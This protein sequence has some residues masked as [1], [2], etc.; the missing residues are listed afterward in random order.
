VI[1]VDGAWDMF[2]C[3]HVSLLRKAKSLGDLLI[4]GVHADAAV[5]RHRGSNYPIM[6]MQ[7]RVLSVLGCRYVDD[8]LLDAPWQVTREMIATLRISA[9]VRG[10]VCDTAREADDPHAVPKAMGIHQ[11]LQSEEPLSLEVITERLSTRRAEVQ[12]RQRSKASQEEQWYRNKHGLTV[13]LASELL[14]LTQTTAQVGGLDIAV[15]AL[16]LAGIYLPRLSYDEVVFLLLAAITT[17]V[18]VGRPGIFHA[19]SSMADD[20]FVNPEDLVSFTLCAVLLRCTTVSVTGFGCVGY[21]WLGYLLWTCSVIILELPLLLF[22]PQLSR[23]SFQAACGRRG[24]K[25]QYLVTHNVAY[26]HLDINEEAAV[27]QFMQLGATC[28]AVKAQAATV[29]ASEPMPVKLT[30]PAELQ[31]DIRLRKRRRNRCLSLQTSQRQMPG[32]S[33]LGRG[34]LHCRCDVERCCK[35]LAEDNYH[36]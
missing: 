32:V 30:G 36:L 28:S 13:R 6:N 23:E 17:V 24:L 11:E 5:N 27:E 19:A 3:G 22:C 8:V 18:Q 1:Y 31:E 33:L 34:G 15:L 16:A 26:Q 20:L 14:P 7:E 10:T 21:S 12:T 9:V 4:V 35:E 29:E 2:H 25:M